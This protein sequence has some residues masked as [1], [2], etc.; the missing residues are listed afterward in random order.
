LEFN[1]L[2]ISGDILEKYSNI[3]F[4]ENPSS[5]SQVPCRWTTGRYDKVNTGIP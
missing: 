3:T 4:W 5:G 1:E 2:K